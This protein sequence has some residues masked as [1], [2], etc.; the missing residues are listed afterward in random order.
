MS[1]GG[2]LARTAWFGWWNAMRRYHRHEV[3]GLHHLEAT[4]AALIVGYH[5][6]PIA[7]DLVMLQAL[8]AE[9]HAMP[10][11]IIHQYFRTWPLLR[12]LY[13]GGE[14]L[15]GDE[16]ELARAFERGEQVIV[17][18]GGTREGTRGRGERYRVSWGGRLGYL[19]LALRHGVPIVPAASWGID[20]GYLALNDGYALGKRV[21][22]PKGLPLWLGIGPLGPWPL[23]PPFPVK[24]TTLLGAPIDLRDGGPVDVT[25]RE[26]LGHLHARVTS[27]VQALLDGRHGQG[28]R[29]PAGR[30]S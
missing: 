20:D 4:G 8:L 3:R 29:E 1:P 12:W 16:G 7:Y 10:R 22:L 25:D 28:G 11:A 23:S 24:I 17:T 6:R 19:K 15:D 5:G 21:G 18:P 27:A 9:R 26:A 30:A 2:A 14:F 13:E